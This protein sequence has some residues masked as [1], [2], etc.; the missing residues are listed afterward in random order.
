M[1]TLKKLAS[2]ETEMQ[3]LKAAIDELKKK[4]PTGPC[5]ATREGGAVRRA[6]MDLSQALVRLRSSAD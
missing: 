6:S 5:W 3:R 4:H 1:I 2:V